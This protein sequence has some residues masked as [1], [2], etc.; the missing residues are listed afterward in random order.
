MREILPYPWDEVA[1]HILKYILYK[2]RMSVV[3]ADHFRLLHEL[4]LKAELPLS[5]RHSVSYFL[6]QSIK[7]MSQKVREGKH[8][9][10]GHD[11]L[12]KLI[13]VDSLNN[14]RIHVLFSKFIYMDKETF[15]ETLA[16][17][18]GETLTYSVGGRERKK[19]GEEEGERP[20]EQWTAGS[21][22]K[23]ERQ[24]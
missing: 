22:E 14:L 10:L 13:A 16:L 19:E 24:N 2:G 6:L 3:Y 8:Q 5:Q 23:K 11:G 20:E 12:I 1:Y 18:L 9:H 15:I 17:T 21:E 4:G 7:E